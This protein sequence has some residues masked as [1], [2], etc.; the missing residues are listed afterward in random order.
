MATVILADVGLFHDF[1]LMVK[2]EAMVVAMM[3][4]QS[5]APLLYILEVVVSWT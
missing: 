1:V 3:L 2:E 4:S 5:V